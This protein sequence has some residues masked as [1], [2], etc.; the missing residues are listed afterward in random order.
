MVTPNQPL[1]GA[2]LKTMD[3]GSYQLQI[4]SP[5]PM[6]VIQEWLVTIGIVGLGLATLWNQ[7]F[8]V[9]TRPDPNVVQKVEQTGTV[10]VRPVDPVPVVAAVVA[11]TATPAAVTPAVIPQPQ[12][13]VDKAA[14]DALEQRLIERIEGLRKPPK[15]P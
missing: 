12:L 7:L 2:T 10:D 8:G 9:M 4:P 3:D 14:L 5:P 15:V 1:A 13:A 6:K 11:D